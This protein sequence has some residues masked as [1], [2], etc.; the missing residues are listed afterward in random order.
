VDPPTGAV[1]GGA[2]SSRER[3]ITRL[4]AAGTSNRSIAMELG[5]SEKTVERHL[6]AIFKRLGFRSRT[7]LA[8]AVARGSPRH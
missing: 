6:T 4:V 5:V 8:A 1:G 7:E 3:Q 2:L